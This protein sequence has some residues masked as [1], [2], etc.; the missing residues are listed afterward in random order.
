MRR[1]GKIANARRRIFTELPPANLESRHGRTSTAH[2]GS[3]EAKEE[4]REGGVEKFTVEVSGVF[5]ADL[6]R[7][8]K[9]HDRNNQH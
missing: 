1:P 8:M 6:K 5:K 7:L 3:Q 4:A 9:D 2:G